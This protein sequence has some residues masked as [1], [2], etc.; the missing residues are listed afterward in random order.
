MRKIA[1]L[2]FLLP[3]ALTGCNKN[4]DLDK[5]SILA[6]TGAP[7]L[8][9]YR[10]YG[11]SNFSTNSGEVSNIISEMVFGNADVAVLPTNVGIKN[12]KNKGLDYKLASTIT[13]GNLFLVSTGNDGN[14]TL[15]NDDYVVLFQKGSVPD[16]IFCDIYNDLSNVHYVASAQV[17][18]ACLASGI[19]VTNNNAKVDYVLMAEPAL[20]KVQKSH[21]EK[22]FKVFA[23]IQTE[24]K[25]KH[26]NHEIFQA[27]I[28]V[29]NGLN[30]EY[31]D[32][33]LSLIKDDIISL[34]NNPDVLDEYIQKIADPQSFLGIDVTSA[35]ES[36]KENNRLG[37]NYRK[38][39]E[40]KG[41]VRTFLEVFG[42]KDINEEVF[43]K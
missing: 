6:P 12:I 23:N 36:L 42:E 20:T 15:D 35:K 25:N 41:D 7:A 2:L 33:F 39:D 40:Y 16:I 28:F 22:D 13:F 30:K 24:Y 34:L 21:P 18:S 26:D 32:G 4:Q 10:F 19:D 29:K 27:S 43:Y 5:I 38:C 8:A 11:N 3:L 31:I 17:A 1:G 37:L 9:F 14:K